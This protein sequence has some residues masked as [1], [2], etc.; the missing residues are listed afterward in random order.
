[1][2]LIEQQILFVLRFKVA[3]QPF[4]I[5]LH[6]YGPQQGG[7]NSLMLASGFNAYREQI[8]MQTLRMALVQSLERMA[9]AVKRVSQCGILEGG[10]AG[11]V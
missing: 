1:M 10:H 2:L 8:P 5:C 6:Q 7:A 11:K 3:G 4:G 9:E